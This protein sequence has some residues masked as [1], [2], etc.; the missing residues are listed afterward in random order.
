MLA[1]EAVAIDIDDAYWR[2]LIFT[3]SQVH[4]FVLHLEDGT[5][6]SPTGWRGRT[7]D[8]GPLSEPIRVD[9]PMRGA[10]GRPS[11]G[12]RFAASTTA[13]VISSK[14]MPSTEIAPRSPLSFRS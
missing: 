11:T 13:K 5:K 3:R 7:R 10:A 8:P 12:K 14:V 4:M 2:R 6:G 9:Q 1:F